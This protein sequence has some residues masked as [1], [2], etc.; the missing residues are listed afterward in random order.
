MKRSNPINTT[1]APNGRK[2][3]LVEST[4]L[5]I[6][7]KGGYTVIEVA[8]EEMARAKGR[9]RAKDLRLI[10]TGKATP[11]EI[12]AKNDFFPGKIEVLDWSPVFA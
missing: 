4:L 8:P 7:K 6:A 9:S 11:E 12:Q 3:G 2:R 5:K 10:A 1:V